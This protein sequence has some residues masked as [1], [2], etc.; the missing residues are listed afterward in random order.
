MIVVAAV[1]VIHPDQ[2]GAGPSLTVHHPVDHLGGE[3][4][5]LPDVLRVLLGVDVEVGVH[6][7]ERGQRS[8]VGIGEE[9]VVPADVQHVPGDAK[10]KD[11]GSELQVLLNPLGHGRDGPAQ[12]EQPPTGHP[13]P[14][15]PIP[16][17]HGLIPG[18]SV[19]V[20]P[21]D[22]VPG[23]HVEDRP[24]GRVV[25]KVEWQVIDEAMRRSRDE[26]TA[27]GERRAQARAEPV[28]GQREGPGQ[29][30]VERNVVFGPVTHGDRGVG[31]RL[32]RLGAGHE[33]LAG[34]VP[35]L[36]MARM[37]A[38]RGRLRVLD[39]G[40]QMV[41]PDRL[42]IAARV[43]QLRLAVWPER[44]ALTAAPQH[45][46]VV[47]VGVVLHHQHNDVLDLRQQ[48]C[49]GRPG[50]LRALPGLQA[51]HETRPALQLVSF[52]P[53]PHDRAT[54]CPRRR[55]IVSRAASGRTCEQ[56]Y[57]VLAAC[58]WCELTRRGQQQVHVGS[59]P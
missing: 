51:A 47:V 8:V 6:D 11:V 40:G 25:E 23:Q 14:V 39:G 34:P 44:E 53:L 57:V 30:V 36:Q 10:R 48:V 3:A 17:D 2:Q 42:A 22:S 5:T 55:G 31:I 20:D 29:A 4:L 15:M 1:L 50:R 19:V 32:D 46:E 12:A 24:G 56:D 18:H 13:P 59:C 52:E 28:I 9:L 41:C 37:P 33:P 38:L 49:A 7:A 16:P 35:P 45:A 54:F 27:V 58:A 21:G 43:G 26:E